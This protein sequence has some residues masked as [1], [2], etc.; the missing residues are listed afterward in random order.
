LLSDYIP[1]LGSWWV[2]KRENLQFR[3]FRGKL[4]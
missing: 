4:F 1:L 3:G 2:L